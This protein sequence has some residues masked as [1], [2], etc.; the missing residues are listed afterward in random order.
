MLD[1]GVELILEG[2]KAGGLDAAMALQDFAGAY[3][4]ARF[5]IDQ[6]DGLEILWQPD[7]PTMRFGEILV[8]V[9]PF[10]FLQPTATGQARSEEHTS[11]LQ[12]LMRIS[13]AVFC[14]KKTNRHT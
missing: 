6:G 10:A 11:E 8:E 4:L 12:S 13:Y 2:V 5:A 14:L 9:P 7:L 3:N 1:Q